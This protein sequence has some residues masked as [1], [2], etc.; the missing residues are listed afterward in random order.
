MADLRNGVFE[1]KNLWRHRGQAVRAEVD[2]EWKERPEVAD[3]RGGHELREP[4]DRLLAVQEGARRRAE[5]VHVPEL[6]GSIGEGPN[7]SNHS[8]H[9]NSF[10]IGIFPRKFKNF[11]NLI[12]IFNIF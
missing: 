4:P 1:G 10:E 8:N 5:G 12:Q 7:H 3:F 11:R 9:S 6:K 2:G